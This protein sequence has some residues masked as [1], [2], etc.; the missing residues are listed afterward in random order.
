LARHD[1]RNVTPAMTW[2]EGDI[3]C[4]YRLIRELG[5]GGM[6]AVWEA[7]HIHLQLNVALKLVSDQCQ[8]YT[9]VRRRFLQEARAAARVVHPNVV[10]VL[11]Y[12]IDPDGEPVLVTELLRGGTLQQWIARRGPLSLAEA[13]SLMKQA[14]EGLHAVH[15]AGVI[16]RDVKAE[17]FFIVTDNDELTVKLIDFGIARQKRASPR[18]TGPMEI[19]GTPDYMSPEQMI[20]P[21]AV[22]ERSDVYALA[23]CMYYC[24]T[25]FLPF[26]GGELRESCPATRGDFAP[27]SSLREHLPSALDAFFIHAFSQ[28]SDRFPNAPALRDGFTTACRAHPGPSAL[29]L[30]EGRVGD[31]L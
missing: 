24:V 10:R 15:R 5:R 1:H 30:L 26:S 29:A 19:V 20:S 13:S 7:E 6:G 9:D 23:V 22:D 17:N 11:G 21:G 4:G 8:A 31:E 25:G 2:T 12:D 14:A 27:P 28:R 16:H 3:I 18:I